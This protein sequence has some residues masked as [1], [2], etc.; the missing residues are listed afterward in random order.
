MS[1]QAAPIGGS[2]D[3]GIVRR[4]PTKF[5]PHPVSGP[6]PEPVPLPKFPG[7]PPPSLPPRRRLHD[8][9]EVASSDILRRSPGKFSPPAVS[10]HSSDQPP[11]SDG[12][13]LPALPPRSLRGEDE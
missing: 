2:N 9:S 13:P 12:Y 8:E 1:A 5:S 7:I 3:D 11:S 6:N 4:S 10:G